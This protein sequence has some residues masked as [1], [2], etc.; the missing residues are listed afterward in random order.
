MHI[1]TIVSRRMAE[2]NN[3]ITTT[4]Q[5]HQQHNNT[6]II[7]TTTNNND[8]PTTTTKSG[9]NIDYCEDM[10]KRRAPIRVE[11]IRDPSLQTCKATLGKGRLI[12]VVVTAAI[13]TSL[14][15]CSWTAQTRRQETQSMASYM[16]DSQGSHADRRQKHLKVG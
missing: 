12:E 3:N 11:E 2:L 6:T 9:Q 10:T 1:P 7:T 16:H 13:P 14:G 8:K 4:Q 5:Q 15:L